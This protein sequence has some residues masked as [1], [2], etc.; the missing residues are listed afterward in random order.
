MFNTN[1]D[2]RLIHKTTV[3]N[4]QYSS[5]DNLFGRILAVCIWAQSKIILHKRYIT[6]SSI[7]ACVTT[8]LLFIT[9]YM[10]LQYIYYYKDNNT[11]V[12]VPRQICTYFNIPSDIT[13]LLC[14]I[15]NMRAVYT[16]NNR[17]MIRIKFNDR[18]QFYRTRFFHECGHSP[19]YD[20]HQTGTIITEFIPN[21]DT[22]LC[23]IY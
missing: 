3:F 1:T 19:T 5:R 23:I 11:S 15:K 12:R 4:S 2:Y 10:Y 9:N 8:L 6:R 22:I 20:I 18:D 7:H 21:A 13:I 14:Y 16:Y 17:S